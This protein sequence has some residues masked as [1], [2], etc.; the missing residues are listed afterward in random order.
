MVAVPVPPVPKPVA[1]LMRATNWAPVLNVN[2]NDTEVDVK[3]RE[4]IFRYSGVSI[5][6]G[7]MMSWYGAVPPWTVTVM[8]LHWIGVES[9]KEKLAAETRL[10]VHDSSAD[11]N[12]KRPVH[13]AGRHGML[14][15]SEEEERGVVTS[16]LTCL[17]SESGT[18]H[19][20]SDG[21]SNTTIGLFRDYNA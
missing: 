18:S 1:S 9:A 20:T 3:L 15:Q 11:S 4:M 12:R 10:E 17:A 13:G 7:M 16:R 5:P 19:M 21:A 14:A 6:D 8:L 2:L